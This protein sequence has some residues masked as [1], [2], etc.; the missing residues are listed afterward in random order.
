MKGEFAD[1]RT[2]RAG[3]EKTKVNEE[4]GRKKRQGLLEEETGSGDDIGWLKM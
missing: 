2:R 4:E 1:V 3:Q